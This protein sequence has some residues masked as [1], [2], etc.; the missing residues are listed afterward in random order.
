[1]MV[2]V[3]IHQ[4]IIMNLKIEILDDGSEAEQS[5]AAIIN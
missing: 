5:I 4:I 3:P 1:M 2:L